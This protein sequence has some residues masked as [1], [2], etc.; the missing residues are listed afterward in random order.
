MIPKQNGDSEMTDKEFKAW[1]LNKAKRPRKEKWFPGQG[2]GPPC[3]GPEDLEPCV[4]AASAPAMAKGNRA[5]SGPQQSYSREARLLEG[6]LRNRNNFII[7][8]LD[9]HSEAQSESQQLQRRQED[10]YTKMGGNQRKK[11]ENTRNQNTSP[12]TRDHNSSPAREQG[13]TETECD[14]MTESGFRT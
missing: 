2:P 10:K 3:C 4:P 14:E 12:P 13:W 6:K 1:T 8:K 9:V 11:D 5:W 7:N